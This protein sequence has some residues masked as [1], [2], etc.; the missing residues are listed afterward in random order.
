[1]LADQIFQCRI[2]RDAVQGV[3]FINV[4]LADCAGQCIAAVLRENIDILRARCIVAKRFENG[5]QIADRHPLAQ[6]ALQHLLQLTRLDHRGHDLID[7][8]R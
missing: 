8:R 2:E 7:Q 3:R 5:F 1:M 6:E 4:L